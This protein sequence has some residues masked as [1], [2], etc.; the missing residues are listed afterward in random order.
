M[1]HTISCIVNNRPGVIAGIT[2]FF[3]HRLININSLSVSETAGEQT[4]RVTIVI[5]C[6]ETSVEPLAAMMAEHKLILKMD[7]LDRTGF[8]D[9][10]LALVKIGARPEDLPRIMQICE[11]MH[12]SVAALGLDSMTLEMT[13]TEQKITAFIRLVQPF[14]VR[15]CAR[16]GRVAVAQEG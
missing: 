1:R 15:E 6:P 9:R 13:G 8:L 12:A 4:S 7:D 14:G 16:S 5:E 11:I 10:E 3:A 2:E